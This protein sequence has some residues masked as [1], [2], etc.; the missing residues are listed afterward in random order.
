MSLGEQTSCYI[1]TRELVANVLSMQ[2]ADVYIQMKFHRYL[3]QATTEARA[4]AEESLQHID[5]Q[6]WAM[7]LSQLS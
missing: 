2:R 4:T 5:L 7:N 6:V 1:V 3:Y